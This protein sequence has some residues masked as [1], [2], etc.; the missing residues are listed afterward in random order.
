M[1]NITIIYDGTLY[2]YK[3][4]KALLW[5]RKEFEKEGASIYYINWNALF[6]IGSMAS[7]QIDKVLSLVERRSLDIVIIAFHYSISNFNNKRGLDKIE[8]LKVLKGRCNRI[9]WLDTADSTG[10]CQFEVLPYVDVYLKKQLLNDLNLY[11]KKL[12]GT[13]LFTDYYH[14]KYA[15]EDSKIEN[16][17]YTLLAPQY[18]DKVKLS[19]NIG[20][21]DFWTRSRFCLVRPFNI[22]VP[23][24]TKIDRIRKTNMFF[25]GTL[26]YSPI[27]GF[28]RRKTIEKMMGN[29]KT[30]DP[31]PT[32]KMNHKRYIDYMK[33]AKTA[34]SPFG[35]GEIC[36]R[37]F[38]SFAY[39]ATLVKPDMSQI[40]T[41][42]EFFIKGETYVSID[43]DFNN[44][45]AI[46]EGI[47][48]HEYMAIAQKG[49]D[50]YNYYIN[51]FDGK[52]EFVK[53]VLS[54]ML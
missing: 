54:V 51:S 36:Y 21:S 35:W 2:T 23:S 5:A 44:F 26:N 52:K 49:Q 37:D 25:N 1:R 3:W 38:E 17:S 30:A 48:S 16:N 13:K 20:I 12:Y 45:D 15:L 41:F 33:N 4:I 6:P 9:V 31:S 10:N 18:M 50:L 8:L 28:Q 47:G 42:P 24:M 7:G 22:Y 27:S 32:L 46:V 14:H 39:G 43:W 29:T 11:T 34:I 19:W 40:T 53:H